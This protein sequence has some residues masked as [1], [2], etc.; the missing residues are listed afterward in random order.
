MRTTLDVDD[1]V[2]AVAGKLAA[3]RRITVDQVISDLAWNELARAH[4]IV[5]NGVPLLPK[6]GGVVTP[7]LV[8]KLLD[9]IDLS[10]AGLQGP[11]A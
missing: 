8:E 9:D 5:R 1:D 3:D 10:D 2:L 7:E 6:R 4:L 11:T